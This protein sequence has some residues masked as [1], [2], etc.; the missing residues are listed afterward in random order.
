MKKI[1]FFL[2][3]LS[4]AAIGCSFD[5]PNCDPVLLTSIP[6]EYLNDGCILQDIDMEPDEVMVT[7]RSQEDLER[8]VGCDTKELNFN[9]NNHFLVA[10][11]VRSHSCG[12]LQEQNSYLTC[13]QL[14]HRLEIVE[15]DCTAITEVKYMVLFPRAFV[16]YE[17]LLEY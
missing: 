16:E 1:S 4:L 5:N 7:I 15:E 10:G 12:F 14:I 8:Y 13:G 3:G 2:I 9:F 11:R 6:L 17:F